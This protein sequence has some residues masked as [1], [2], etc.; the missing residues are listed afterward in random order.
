[1]ETSFYSQQT[2]LHHHQ[3][4]GNS[5]H[6]IVAFIEEVLSALCPGRKP[7]GRCFPTTGL[8]R[9]SAAQRECVQDVYVSDMI[10]ES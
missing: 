5:K 3:M 9:A 10:G 4:H 6:F 1:M 2:S 7:R 8:G